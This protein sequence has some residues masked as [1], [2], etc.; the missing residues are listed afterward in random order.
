MLKYSKITVCYCIHKW[1]FSSFIYNTYYTTSMLAINILLIGPPVLF[2]FG[3][4]L[5][6]SYFINHISKYLKFHSEFKTSSA[7][8]S[9]NQVCLLQTNIFFYCASYKCFIVYCCGEQYPFLFCFA[10]SLV[11]FLPKASVNW[12][13]SRAASLCKPSHYICAPS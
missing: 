8:K 3:Y 5:E 4:M 11:F 1:I 2:E 12:D 7:L 10:D 6:S 9:T 13:I